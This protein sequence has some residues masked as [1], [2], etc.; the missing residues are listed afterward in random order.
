MSRRAARNIRDLT[1]TTTGHQTEERSDDLDA[2]FEGIVDGLRRDVRRLRTQL[3][4]FARTYEKRAETQAARARLEP[5]DVT[6]RARRRLRQL[7]LVVTHIESSTSYLLGSGV[8]PTHEEKD[9]AHEVAQRVLDSLEAERER[10]YRDVHD[11]PAQAL[12]N[13]IFEIEYLERI[14]ERAP[15]EVGK[16]LRTELARLKTQFRGSLDAVRAMIYDLRPPVLSDLGLAGA[17]RDY[18]SEYQARYGMTVSCQLEAAE[19]GLGPQ[20]EL[21]VYRVMQEALQ[22]VH[23]H[24]NATLVR[25]SWERNAARWRLSCQ[26]DGQGFDLVKAARLRR[27]VGLFAMR[28]RAELIGGTLQIQSAP[29]QGTTVTLALPVADIDTARG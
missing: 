9:E 10:L 18:A 16:P 12:A 22:N 17:I 21:A 14:T 3:E 19:T 25:L 6:Q 24:A 1:Q 4:R 11:G 20:Q 29:G 13:A 8:A 5:D 27:S 2:Q 7:R 28:E 26:D 23:K 15:A